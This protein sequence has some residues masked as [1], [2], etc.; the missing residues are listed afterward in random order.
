VRL[1]RWLVRAFDGYCRAMGSGLVAPVWPVPRP[2]PPP[3]PGPVPVLRQARPVNRPPRV[4]LPPDPAPWGARPGC[5][6]G[7]AWTDTPQGWAAYYRHVEADTAECDAARGAA[8]RQRQRDRAR[9]RRQAIASDPVLA[10]QLRTYEREMDQREWARIKADPERL[11]AE[12][13]RRRKYERERYATDPDY[14]ERKRARD[15]ARYRTRALS[16]SV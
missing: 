2:M 12:R 13:E 15:R 5:W 16:P 6:C 7:R 3:E 11:E 14:R 10:A 1:G 4:E 9:Q 8:L